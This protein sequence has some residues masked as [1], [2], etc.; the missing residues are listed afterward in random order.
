MTKGLADEELEGFKAEIIVHV[1]PVDGDGACPAGEEMNPGHGGLPT[2]GAVHVRLFACIHRFLP[3]LFLG[4]GNRLL[5]LVLVD[6]ALEDAQA[7]ERQAV[8]IVLCH[9]ALDSQLHGKL[10]PL[11]H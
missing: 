8:E 5:R 4:P 1:A 2:A 9:H 3:P 10:G 11:G 6:V 7:A